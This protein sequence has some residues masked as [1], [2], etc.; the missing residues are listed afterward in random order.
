VAT[1]SEGM[2]DFVKEADRLLYEAKNAGKGLVRSSSGNKLN[3]GIPRLNAFFVPVQNGFE[4]NRFTI[5]DSR[6]TNNGSIVYRL[7]HRSLP[8]ETIYLIDIMQKEVKEMGSSLLLTHERWN[9]IYS[10]MSRPLR[11]EYPGAWYHV[12]NRG[13]RSESIFSDKHDYEKNWGS[14]L[15]Y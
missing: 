14:N 2:T 12:M 5:L 13:R 10:T 1:Y 7:G 3:L 15:H 4:C 8:P 6:F 11:I 9:D